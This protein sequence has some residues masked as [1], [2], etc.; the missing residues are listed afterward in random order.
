MRRLSL[1]TAFVLLVATPFLPAAEPPLDKGASG[2]I[3]ARGQHLARVLEEM[4]VEKYWQP[5]VSVNWKT[6][7]HDPQVGQHATHCSA[8]AAA[9]CERFGVYILRPP[10]HSQVLLANAQQKWF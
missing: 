4:E 9:A 5:G 8:F 7:R 3:T 1:S 10:E 2:G 6:G